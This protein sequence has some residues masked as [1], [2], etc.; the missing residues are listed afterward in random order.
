MKFQGSKTAII[1][2]FECGSTSPRF[3]AY[4]YSED[5]VKCW[6]VKALPNGWWVDDEEGLSADGSIWGYCAKCKPSYLGH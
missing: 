4:L 5:G 1:Q 6:D 3:K 2:C